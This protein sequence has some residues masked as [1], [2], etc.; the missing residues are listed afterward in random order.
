MAVCKKFPCAVA[1]APLP[2]AIWRFSAHGTTGNLNLNYA[3]DPPEKLPHLRF[4]LAAQSHRSRAAAS[5]R[6]LREAR[7]AAAP[8]AP[9]SVRAGPL[10][11]HGRREGLRPSANGTQCAARN[12]LLLLLVSLRHKSDDAGPSRRHRARGNEGEEKENRRGARHWL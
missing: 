12:S 2:A 8:V 6:L 3:P 4:N 10:R 11:S 9:H 5:P 1:P 7:R